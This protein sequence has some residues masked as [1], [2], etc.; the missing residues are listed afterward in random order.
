MAPP[1][2]ESAKTLGASGSMAGACVTR[3]LVLWRCVNKTPPLR[4]PCESGTCQN[5]NLRLFFRG[6]LP[7]SLRF[8]EQHD[9]AGLL[10]ET[11]P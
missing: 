11:R 8:R 2:K 7:L 6:C 4:R 10:S 1:G 3:P 9:L 5:E